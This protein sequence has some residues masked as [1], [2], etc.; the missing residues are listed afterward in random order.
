MKFNIERKYAVLK[1]ETKAKVDLYHLIDLDS[2]DKISALGVKT[3]DVFQQLDLVSVKLTL[4]VNSERV[5]TGD[6]VKYLQVARTFISEI[7]RVKADE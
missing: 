4:N 2:G 5:G 1:V 7:D 3:D 6:N